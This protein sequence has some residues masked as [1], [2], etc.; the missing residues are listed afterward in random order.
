M[1][2]TRRSLIRTAGIAAA[3][4]VFNLPVLRP[5]QAATLP[6][7]KKRGYMVV[8][9]EDDF[10]PF[11]FVDNGNPTG[12]DTELLKILAKSAPFKIQQERIPWN[13]IL[14]GVTT[15][16]YDAAVSAVLITKERL[17][18]LEFVS[19][20]AE[21]T[22]YYL[23][24][25]NDNSI[26]AIK[27]L[28]GKSCGV[29]QGSAMLAK[30]PQLEAMLKKTGGTMGKVVQYVSYPEAYQ[31]LAIGRIDYVVNTEVNLRTMVREHPEQ[32]AVGQAVSSTTYIAWAVKK[33]NTGVLDFLNAFLLKERGNG[34]MYALQAKWLGQSFKHM[35]VHWTPTD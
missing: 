2:T 29:E 6:E 25:K 24:R 11:E 31:D 17:G 22:D 8:A 20:V 7:I 5:A 28:S 16:K 1:I 35:P 12:Y 4:G 19:P 18:F 3:I 27:D 21:A 34:Q 32:F 33:G 9:T 14:A 13:G 26:K 23:K 10:R 15:G 30:L